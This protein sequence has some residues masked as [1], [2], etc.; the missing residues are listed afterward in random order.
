MKLELGNLILIYGMTVGVFFL[1]DLLWLGAL[2]KDLYAKHYG[3]LLREQVN[4]TAALIF[5][6]IYIGGIV[7]FVLMPALQDG[8]SL[9]KTAVMGGL[10]GFFAYCTFDLTGLA[11]FKNWPLGFAIVDIAWGTIL[12]GSTATVVL[13]LSRVLLK[14]G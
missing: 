7:L 4:W 1:I 14:V 3:P 11:L 13:W 12:T 9:V 2:A 6:A 8:S 10:L 5:Y